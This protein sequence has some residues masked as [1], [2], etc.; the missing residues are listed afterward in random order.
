MKNHIKISRVFLNTKEVIREQLVRLDNVKSLSSLFSRFAHKIIS[1]SLRTNKKIT[2]R[3]RL[4]HKFGRY[5]FNMNKRHGSTYVVKYLKACNLAVSKVIANQPFKSLREIEPDLPLPRLT[6]GGLPVI[7]G[8]RD[9]RSIVQGS[10]KVIRMYLSLFSL[11]R[12]IVIESKSKL[13]TITDAYDGN[14]LYLKMLGSWFRNNTES[15]IGGFNVKPN[16][17]SHNFLFRE[18]ASPSSSKS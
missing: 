1:L 12:V 10:T 15:V 17:S 6:S 5:L 13:N 9:R 11:Y 2:S 18:T 3:I 7:I 8:T 16:I 14:E 4:Y